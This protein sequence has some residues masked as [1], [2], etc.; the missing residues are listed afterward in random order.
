MHYPSNPLQPGPIY[1]RTQRKCAIFGVWDEASNE[2][3]SYLIDEPT[4]SNKGANATISNL[5]HYLQSK[6]SL[7]NPVP[8]ADNCLQVHLIFSFLA[9]FN[10]ECQH[11]A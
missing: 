2:Y 3:R 1:F 5:H 4:V 7:P 9:S 6:P 10:H 8:Y 11:S